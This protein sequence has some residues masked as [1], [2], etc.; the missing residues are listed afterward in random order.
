MPEKQDKSTWGFLKVQSCK[1]IIKQQRATYFCA[2]YD[3]WT[4]NGLKEE[5]DVG[6]QDRQSVAGSSINSVLPDT[7]VVAAKAAVQK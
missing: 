6:S 4:E 1:S 7:F 5:L 2:L 3:D